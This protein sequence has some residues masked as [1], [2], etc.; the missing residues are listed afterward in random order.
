[1]RLLALL[2]A[3][4]ALVAAG[5]AGDDEVAALPEGKFIAAS[6]TMSPKVALFAEPVT[7]RVDVLVDRERFDPDRIE[8]GANFK[9]YERDG[10]IRRTRR[11]QG[12]YTH[13][14]FEY[15][16]RCLVYECLPEVGGGPPQVQPGGIPPPVTSQ[17]GGFGERKTVSLPAASVVYDDPEKGKQPVTNVSWPVAQIVSR[18]NFGD[19]Q[20]TG[21][22]FPFEAS[23]TPLTEPT[24]RLS[25]GVL[26]AGLIGLALLLL[27]LPV[28]LIVRALRKEDGIVE[29][30]EPELSPLE[31]ALRLVEWSRDQS[32]EERRE[33]L[34]ALAFELDEPEPELAR[35]ARRI[36]WT[37]PEPDP[38]AMGLLVEAVRAALPAE[39]EAETDVADGPSELA[40]REEAEEEERDAAPA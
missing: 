6:Q 36:A 23:T 14:R 18:L 25:P 30:A 26:A 37:P 28:A 5:C 27:A 21:I 19:T 40:E 15:T 33:A 4:L 34:E 3:A 7:A 8:I 20:V 31:K 32:L 1:M 35:E 9:P 16:L 10:E 24:Y 38:E 2:V 22:G 39:S 29:E 11:D 12:Q 13:L 17:G